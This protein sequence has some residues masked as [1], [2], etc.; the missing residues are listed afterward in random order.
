MTF[1]LLISHTLV[2]YACVC[3]RGTGRRNTS[4]PR[5]RGK[6]QNHFSRM[7]NSVAAK[8]CPFI[9][10][11]L[12]MSTNRKNSSPLYW[13]DSNLFLAKTMD[14]VREMVQWEK[15]ST[16]KPRDQFLGTTWWK[17]KRSVLA[18]CI[19]TSTH[20]PWCTCLTHTHVHAVNL[21]KIIVNFN[22]TNG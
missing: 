11:S 12:G 2:E 1:S 21:K 3:Y 15:I 18:C 7:R 9:W 22:K 4:S 14:G 6:S 17:E 13:M 16:A 10:N 20:A 5:W 19:L 8:F